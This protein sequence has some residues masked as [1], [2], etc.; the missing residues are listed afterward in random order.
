MTDEPR[1]E[2]QPNISRPPSKED[3]DEI[4]RDQA[5]IS[6]EWAPEPDKPKPER[7]KPA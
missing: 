5:L 3:L 1:T 6:D 2:D 7:P 4:S